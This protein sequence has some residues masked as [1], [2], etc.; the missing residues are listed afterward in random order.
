MKLKRLLSLI[1]AAT[2]SVSTLFTLASC[3][4]GQKYTVGIV[5]LIQHPALDSA[6]Q[7][8]KDALI[9]ELG[10]DNVKAIAEV[11]GWR[12]DACAKYVAK[13]KKWKYL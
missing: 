7:G 6:T 10:A 3:G 2:L 13:C 1:L 11:F 8:F 4:G 5:Q 12:E 9:E